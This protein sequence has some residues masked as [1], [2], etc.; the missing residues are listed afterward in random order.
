[1]WIFYRYART[2]ELGIPFCLTIDFD[3]LNDNSVTLRERDSTNQI[4]INVRR[5]MYIEPRYKI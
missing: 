2:D 5:Y 4:R 1:M 3:T